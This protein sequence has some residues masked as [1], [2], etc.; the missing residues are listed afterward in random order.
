MSLILHQGNHLD[1]SAQPGQDTCWPICATGPVKLSMM[2]SMA[3]H[4]IRYAKRL[5]FDELLW[6]RIRP[7]LMIIETERRKKGCRLAILD[8]GCGDGSV[9]RLFL[10]AGHR[11]L[12]IDIVPEFVDE[13]IEKGI[14]AKAADVA[15]DGLPLPEGEID[16]VYA[17]ALIEHLYDPEFFLRECRRVLKEKGLLV[18]STPNIA[19][20]TSRL[21]MLLGKGPKFYT[22]ALSWEFGGHIRIFTSSTLR[23]LLEENGFAVEKITSNLVSFFPTRTTRRPW[24]MALGKLRPS[25]GEVL[26]VK[27]RKRPS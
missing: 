26:I 6:S 24:S 7:C 18:L 19:S 2:D 16:V 10:E 25:L 4:R 8:V 5:V 22:S 15:R 12:G 11:V 27:S 21:R 14:E 9:S 20:L 13:A 1:G 23:Q 3:F 17:G